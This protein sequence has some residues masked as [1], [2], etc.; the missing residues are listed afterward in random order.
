MNSSSDGDCASRFVKAASNPIDNSYNGPPQG[1][2]QTQLDA[3]RDRIS[4]MTLTLV[5]LTVCTDASE[6]YQCNGCSLTR[7]PVCLKRASLMQIP[8]EECT[9]EKRPG[10]PFW[11]FAG[12]L[13]IEPSTVKLLMPKLYEVFILAENRLLREALIRPLNK[14]NEVRVVGANGYSPTV[15]EEIIAVR[16]H[17]VL[18]DSNGLSFARATLIP[19]LQHAIRNL[20][21]VMLGM[22]LDENTFL[23]AV[24]AG[25]V[26]YILQDASTDD[27]VATI[28]AV[29]AGQAVCPP[30]LSMFCFHC[31]AQQ[32]AV[33]TVGWGA[34]I[35]LSRREQQMV[36]LLCEQLTNKEIAARLNLSDQTIKNHVHHI[37]RKVGVCSRSGIVERCRS[38]LLSVD[39]TPSQIR[40]TTSC[41][42]PTLAGLF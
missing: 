27:V 26:G 41:T 10:F 16:P 23:R 35:R 36:E 30:S 9:R 38:R 34:D 5:V 1:N 25:V 32:S 29:G 40:P 31:I 4:H 21:V 12:N 19:T 42:R 3:I 37:L 28:R 6:R 20:R 15:H 13:I 11:L 8:G 17:I 39:D 33:P 24:R 2:K 14:K 18:L 7:D 22:E